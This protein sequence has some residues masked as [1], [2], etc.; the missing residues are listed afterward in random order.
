MFNIWKIHTNPLKLKQ[1]ITF[2]HIISITTLK[3]TSFVNDFGEYSYK[4]VKENLLFGYDLKPM[5]DNRTIQF[6]I[7]EK[8]LLDLLMNYCVKFQS[9]ALDH[10]VKLL[11]KTYDL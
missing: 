3:T 5:A 6:A 1:F 10:R 8:A 7:P 9:K 4:N 2:I 11:L